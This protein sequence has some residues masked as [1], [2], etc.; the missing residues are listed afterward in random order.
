M[1]RLHEKYGSV[2]RI[3]PRRLSYCNAAA[4]KAIHGRRTGFETKTFVKDPV[5]YIF[6]STEP[7]SM[8]IANDADHDRH[9]QIMANSFSDKVSLV[10]RQL[11][12]YLYSDEDTRL[13]ASKSLCSSDG[14]VI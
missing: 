14:S 11:C 7:L 3:A 9:R 2:V 1:L 13:F 8:H 6:D 4:W 10:S 12:Q 5:Y